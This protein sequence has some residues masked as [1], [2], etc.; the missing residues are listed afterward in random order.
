[1]CTVPCNYT[2]AF[3]FCSKDHE[4]Y[5]YF[6]W[7]PSKFSPPANYS[8]SMRMYITLIDAGNIHEEGASCVLYVTWIYATLISRYQ[9]QTK[10][11][12]GKLFGSFYLLKVNKI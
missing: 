3:T 7:I 6:S 11:K 2:L 12:D 8:C 9:K 4:K 5:I 1:M 10:K